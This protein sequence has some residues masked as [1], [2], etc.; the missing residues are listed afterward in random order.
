MK[1]PI[2]KSREGHERTAHLKKHFESAFGGDSRRP[3]FLISV[4]L[5][6]CPLG[7]HSDH[8]GGTVT[9]LTID[10]SVQLLGQASDSPALK[11]FSANFNEERQVSFD[12]IPEKTPGD[13]GNY[14]RGMVRA[15]R[16]AE[17]FVSRGFNAVIHGE[18]PIGGLSSSAAVS[19]AYAKAL[20]H[21]NHLSLSPLETILLVRA[22]ENGYLGLHNGILDQSVIVS[23]RPNALTCINCHSHEISTLPQEHTPQPWEIVVVYSGLS[24]Q[25]TGTPFNQRVAECHEAARELL[26]LAGKPVPEKPLLGDVGA[27]NFFEYQSQL[28]ETLQ[29]RARH[30]FTEAARVH[31]GMKVWPS[32]DM[33]KFGALVTASGESSIV[34]F[35]SGSPALIALYEILASTPG[36]Y[37]SRFCGG[38]F[39]GCCLALIDPRQREAIAERLHA[40]YMARHP[41]LE[42]A[43]SIHFC[44]SADS[45]SLEVME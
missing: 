43:Y 38:G 25:L 2:Q 12:S 11:V 6:I 21:V 39:Q 5:R 7:A 10:R 27:E 17:S 34:N 15:M 13:W 29:R 20:E 26:M 14:A 36:V 23:S 1:I 41:E 9:G 35:E 30:F 8:Q 16:Q 4:P 40:A 19:I 37:G 33:E 45:V 32:G 31:E 44:R 22:T 42:G 18:M 28:P 24:R 3:Y